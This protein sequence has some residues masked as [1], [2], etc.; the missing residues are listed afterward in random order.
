MKIFSKNL[1]FKKNDSYSYHLQ[2]THHIG[3][4]QT[5]VDCKNDRC[6]R[7]SH[8]SPCPNLETRE[9]SDAGKTN[10]DCANELY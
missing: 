2:P 7:A 1:I 9:H 3:A 6:R 10:A 5:I 8:K 4:C